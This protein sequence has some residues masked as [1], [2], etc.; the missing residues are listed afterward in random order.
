MNVGQSMRNESYGHTVRRAQ[1]CLARNIKTGRVPKPDSCD[2][3][4]SSGLELRRVIY[5][6]HDALT[7]NVYCE[8]CWIDHRVDQTI[9]KRRELYE[10]SPA[11]TRH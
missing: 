8:N 5:N 3:C 1:A 9:D 6:P 11:V 10:P 7:F 4:G 2:G